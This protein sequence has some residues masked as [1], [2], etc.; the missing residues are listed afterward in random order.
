MGGVGRGLSEGRRE[1][2]D[3]RVVNGVRF[4]SRTDFKDDRLRLATI[5]ETM[6]VGFAGLKPGGVTRSQ[7]LRPFIRDQSYLTA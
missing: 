5:L 7:Q 6:P 1:K 4:N 2:V 3:I